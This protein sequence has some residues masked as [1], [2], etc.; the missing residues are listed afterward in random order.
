VVTARLVQDELA[1]ARELEGARIDA[2]SEALEGNPDH[3]GR[4]EYEGVVSL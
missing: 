3:S 4:D 2:R 1:L